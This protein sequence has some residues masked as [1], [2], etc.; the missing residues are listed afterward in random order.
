[1]KK[2]YLWLFAIIFI[3]PAS[4]AQSSLRMSDSKFKRQFLD[5]INDLRQR[6]CN[7]GGSFMPP[8]PALRW[9]D[10]LTN[11]AQG[12]AMDMAKRH[13]FSHE[14]KNGRT[15]RQRVL[16]VGYDYKGIQKW[17]VGENIAMGQHSIDEVMDGWIESEGHCKNLMSPQFKEVGIYE[18]KYFWVQDF[19]G[20]TSF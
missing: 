10:V 8:V 16:A 15:L 18:Y 17:A 4:I 7:C 19:G 5:R 6:G 1:M 2:M 20:R 13:Y 14:S 12:H 11:A 3:V 9:S